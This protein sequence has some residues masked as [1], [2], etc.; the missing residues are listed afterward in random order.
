[1]PI[2]FFCNQERERKKIKIKNK[3]AQLKY[4]NDFVKKKKKRMLYLSTEKLTVEAHKHDFAKK[5]KKRK[6]KKSD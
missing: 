5:E 4:T 2:F 3:K 1:M 6:E